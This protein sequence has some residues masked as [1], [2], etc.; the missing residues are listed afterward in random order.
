[1]RRGNRR[2]IVPVALE[3]EM[4]VSAATKEEAIEEA[5]NRMRTITSYGA[6]AGR[7]PLVYANKAKLKR[8]SA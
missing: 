3:W 7:F 4:E 5:K 8:E 1:M 6:N 2:Y